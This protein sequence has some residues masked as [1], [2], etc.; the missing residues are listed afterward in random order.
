MQYLK[1]SGTPSAPINLR[2]VETTSRSVTIKWSPPESDGGSPI[3][4]EF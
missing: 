2:V 1:F 4:G 3:I